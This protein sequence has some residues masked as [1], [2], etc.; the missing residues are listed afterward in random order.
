MRTIETGG[1]TYIEPVPGG[2]AAWYY[3]ISYEHGDTLQEKV[4]NY[5]QNEVDISKATL[6]SVIDIL[7]A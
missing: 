7:K 5:L 3:G 6:D 2:T 1:I 4:Y